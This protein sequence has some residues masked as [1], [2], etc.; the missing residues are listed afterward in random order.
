MN[1]R[2][3]IRTWRIGLIG[4]G[5]ITNVICGAGQYASRRGADGN[6]S[7]WRGCWRCVAPPE[8]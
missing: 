4:S 6:L 7:R 1:G 3:P 8:T 5:F 2:N